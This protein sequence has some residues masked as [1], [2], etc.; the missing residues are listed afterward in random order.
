M[1]A[2][3]P[4]GLAGPGAH[5]GHESVAGGHAER[6]VAMEPRGHLDD[7]NVV[8]GDVGRLDVT[9]AGCVGK[10]EMPHGGHLRLEG[11]ETPEAGL[12]R[13][14]GCVLIQG[15]QDLRQFYDPQHVPRLQ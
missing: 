6:W 14:K 7:E 2:Q 5:H 8:A 10:S 13:G 9:V 3:D 12:D 1:V 15:R 11:V 4:Q